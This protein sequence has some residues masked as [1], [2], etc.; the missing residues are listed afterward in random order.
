MKKTALLLV[1]VLLLSM[2]LS[3][4][5]VIWQVVKPKDAEALW[6]RVDEKMSDLKSYRVEVEA[7]ISFEY[8]GSEVEGEM[9]MTTVSIGDEDDENPYYYT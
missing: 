5:D 2:A 1:I 4:C 3:S 7:D 9:S 8:M 6:E